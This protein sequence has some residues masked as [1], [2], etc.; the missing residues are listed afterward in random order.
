MKEYVFQYLFLGNKEGSVL[1][2]LGFVSLWRVLFLNEAGVL[3]GAQGM[4]E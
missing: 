1:F 2:W 3:A 4:R